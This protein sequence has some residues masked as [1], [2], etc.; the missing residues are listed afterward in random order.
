[1][2]YDEIMTKIINKLGV[3]ADINRQVCICIYGVVLPTPPWLRRQNG[4]EYTVRFVCPLV[5]PVDSPKYVKGI[6]LS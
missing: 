6:H 2:W 1:M 4:Y 5:S 3:G